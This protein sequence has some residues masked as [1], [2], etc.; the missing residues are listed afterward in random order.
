DLTNQAT[1]TLL[2]RST[3]EPAGESVIV[4]QTS[5]GLFLGAIILTNAPPAADGLLSVEN[6]ATI[7]VTYVDADNGMGGV[8]ITNT[9]TAVIDLAAPVITGV[10]VT[11]VTDTSATIV[12]Q[13]DEAARGNLHL[14]DPPRY[15]GGASPATAHSVTLTNLS[16]GA[17]YS[18]FL[19]AQDV[20]GNTATNDNAGQLFSFTT[21]LFMPIWQSTAELG[22]PLAWAST[23]TW[24]QSAR[25]PLAGTRSWYCGK[26]AAGVYDNSISSAL[27]S[28]AITVTTASASLR[29]REFISTELSYDF[30]A[31]QVSTN[32][33]ARW[34]DLRP[35]FSGSNYVRDVLLPL[36]GFTPG[37]LQL[38][39][40]FSSDSS[41][42]HEGWYLDALQLG[43][44]VESGLIVTGQRVTDPPPNGDNDGF[45][46]PGE[47]IAL[48][49]LLFNGRATALTNLFGTLAC[50][51][52]FVAMLDNTHDFG[53]VAPG[54]AFSN[55]V[56]FTFTIAPGATNG[57]PLA[58]MLACVADD[59]TVV[60]NPFTLAV[61]LRYAF[62]GLARDIADQTAITNAWVYW[63]DSSTHATPVNA[64]GAFLVTGLEPRAYT[65]WADADGYAASAVLNLTCPP[66]VAGLVLELGKPVPVCVP[67]AFNLQLPQDDRW[68]E[69]LTVSNAG[70]GTLAYTLS[71]SNNFSLTQGFDNAGTYRWVDSDAP[72]CPPFAWIDIRTNG[73]VVALG[74]DQTSERLSLAHVFPFYSQS[75]S[76]LWIGANG[77]IALHSISN[78]PVSNT[79]LPANTAPL[80][81]LAPF[82]DDL[83]PAAGGTIYFKSFADKTVVSYVGVQRYG[84]AASTMTFQVI[85]NANGTIRYQYLGM[86]GTLTSATIGWQGD[87]RTKYAQIAYNTSYVRSNLVIAIGRGYEWLQLDG[88]AGSVLPF[89][90]TNLAVA[91]DSHGVSTGIYAGA[92]T[93]YSEGGTVNVP[94]TLTVVPEP[95][96]L[97]ALLGALLAA[98]SVRQG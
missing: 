78:V 68:V 85:L 37:I 14:L 13:T 70:F 24:H 25:R 3:R 56:P 77:G 51:S 26:D 33:G 86:N 65:V 17:T 48:H 10:V 15:L 18:F 11:N 69:I 55:D 95:V 92:V 83:N 20:F 98:R 54:V 19:S 91:F 75:L 36:T 52:P 4:T 57:A 2:V 6:A 45:I 72:D 79:T 29:L 50:A 16:A 44:Y 66:D 80:E 32:R 58:F 30:C 89:A 8:A 12:W 62:A 84:E 64:T 27:V 40:L 49:A 46:E 76:G 71:P 41:V 61:T 74:D 47:T 60:S 43:T 38:R 21:K 39:F 59:G 7:T 94:A 22:E 93:L 31:V 82:W 73:Q 9:A 42:V 5:P 87:N 1:C 63:Q 28:V 88:A 90:A 53:T 34:H 67:A 81:F 35:P 97:L 23:G 96:L